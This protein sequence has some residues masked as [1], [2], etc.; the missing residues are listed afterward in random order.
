MV[1]EVHC[2]VGRGRPLIQS[3][4]YDDDDDDDDREQDR[5][6][7]GRK[8]MNALRTCITSSSA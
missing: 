6:K 8:K 4:I 1:G 3:C 7:G 2:R 5:K